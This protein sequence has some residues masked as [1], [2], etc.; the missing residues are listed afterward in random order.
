MQLKRENSKMGKLSEKVQETTS[1]A[2]QHIKKVLELARQLIIVA[3]QGEL[4]CEDDGCYVLYGIIRDCA[5]KIKN[6][7][8]HER[9]IHKQRGTWDVEEGTGTTLP[10]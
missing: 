7:A 2:N 10:K 4:D 3:D 6:Q 1:K 8:E 5:Y 9:E